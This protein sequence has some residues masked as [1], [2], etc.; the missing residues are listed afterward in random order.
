MEEHRIPTRL[1]FE[2]ALERLLKIHK[3]YLKE[4]YQDSPIYTVNQWLRIASPDDI[5]FL[6]FNES[7]LY[8]MYWQH[9]PNGMD[10]DQLLDMYT[11]G[12]LSNDKKPKHEHVPTPIEHTDVEH[13]Y[14][15]QPK[16]V[17]VDPAYFQ[18]MYAIAKQRVTPRNR[19]DIHRARKEVYLAFNREKGLAEAVGISPRELNDWIR[20]FGGLNVEKRQLEARLNSNIPEEHQWVG[21]SNCHWLKGQIIEPVDLDK[22]VGEIEVTKEGTGIWKSQ[23]EGNILR[24]YIMN[25]FL[26]IDTRIDYGDLNFKIGPCS[27]A[28]SGGDYHGSKKLITISELSENHVAHEIGH[29]LDHKWGSEYGV[30]DGDYISDMKSMKAS[31]PEVHKGWIKQFQ[32]FIRHLLYKSDISSAYMQETREV[33]A[34][35]I[36]KFQEWTMP[37]GSRWS[38]E[39]SNDKFEES[40][41]A[42][43]VRLLQEKSYIDSMWPLNLN[44]K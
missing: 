14:P 12:K 42:R 26:A 10:T 21:L 24:R 29:Y 13:K 37:K 6:L 9:L 1:E 5:A 43:F 44:R 19:T 28:T 41:Y 22:F 17:N 27:K 31:I 38:Q 2:D 15:W 35:F 39:Y 18:Q 33:F 8:N 34:R 23:K 11:S 40:D 32:S 25:T 16:T 20:A 36:N 4:E 30:W 3:E 7:S